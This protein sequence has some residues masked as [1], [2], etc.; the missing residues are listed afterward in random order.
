[1]NHPK[2]ESAAVT[3]AATTEAAIAQAAVAAVICAAGSSA[4]MGTHIG[5]LKKEYR[6]LPVTPDS[7]RSGTV[8][9]LT[10]L[11]SA[12][13]AFAAVPEIKTIVITVPADPLTGESAARKA[14][15]PELFEKNTGPKIYF[16][17][18]GNTRQASVFNALSFISENYAHPP[19]Y[20]LIHDGARPWVSPSLIERIIAGTKKY[21]AVIPLMPLT[22]TPKE[23]D[24]PLDSFTDDRSLGN[25]DS[26]YIKRQLKRAF[27]GTAQTP[28]GFLFPEILTAHKNAAN[29]VANSKYT[30]DAEVWAA[31]YG[32]VA[33][34]PGEAENRKITFPEDLTTS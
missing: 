15:P 7:D 12:V 3:Q 28:Q 4:R 5:G 18:G 9:N 21:S 33:V 20:V 30:D 1:L 16:V 34:I 10:V 31:F 29:K 13:A 17:C 2:N 23:T 32:P 14:L 26:V 24:L 6:P 25:L 19:V 11:G 22:E 27:I 8:S